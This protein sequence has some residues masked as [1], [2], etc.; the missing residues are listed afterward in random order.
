[1]SVS[2]VYYLGFCCLSE[3]GSKSPP[4]PPPAISFFLSNWLMYT[5]P[6]PLFD[7]AV[8]LFIPL[9]LCVCVCVHVWVCVSTAAFSSCL[10]FCQFFHSDLLSGPWPWKWH[11]SSHIK[12]LQKTLTVCTAYIRCLFSKSSVQKISDKTC[13]KL[14]DSQ[15]SSLCSTAEGFKWS[16]N[17]I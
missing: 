3:K 1:M 9:S 8:C 4:P 10:S 5:H 16:I 15:N 11:T 7:T 2:A 14:K 6:H 17:Q 13:Y 12:S